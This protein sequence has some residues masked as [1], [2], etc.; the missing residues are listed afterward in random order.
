MI[1][2][3]SG[4]IVQ[5][6]IEAG[7][8]SLGSAEELSGEKVGRP[9]FRKCLENWLEVKEGEPKHLYLQQ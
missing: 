8:S 7:P 5:A 6:D 3:C 2:R 9:I 4:A 1:E